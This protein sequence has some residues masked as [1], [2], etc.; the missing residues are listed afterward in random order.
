M[1]YKQYKTWWES[2]PYER[3]QIKN[4]YRECLTENQQIIGL[5]DETLNGF[6]KDKLIQII[7]QLEKLLTL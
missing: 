7:H 4:R 1:T 5:S 2:H 3:S 6:K